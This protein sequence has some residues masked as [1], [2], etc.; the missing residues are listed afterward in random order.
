LMRAC[1]SLFDGTAAMS[2]DDDGI[3]RDE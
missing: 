1:R 2:E 3:I